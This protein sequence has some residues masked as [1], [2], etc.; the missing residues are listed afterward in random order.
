MARDSLRVYAGF[1][2]LTGRAIGFRRAGV[3]TIAGPERPAELERLPRLAQGMRSIGIDAR[4]VNPAEMR[5]LGN[6]NV[7]DGSLGVWEPGGGYVDPVRTVEQFAALARSLGAVTRTRVAVRA[8]DVR[9]GRVVGLETDEGH[10]ATEHVVVVAGPWSAAL[11]ARAGVELPLRVVRP[12]Q[13]FQELPLEDLDAEEPSPA[14]LLDPVGKLLDEVVGHDTASRAAGPHPVI[15]DLEHGFYTRCD[16]SARRTRVGRID[17][18]HDRV[19]AD[20]DQ[21]DEHVD[22][23]FATWAERSLRRR[24][25]LYDDLPSAGDQAAWYTLSPDA[26]AL[27]GPVDGIEGLL[28]ATGFSGHGFKLAPSVAQGLVQMLF[29]EPV[30]AF[31]REFF[32]PARFRGKPASWSGAFGL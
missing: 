27:I 30:T 6:A 23:T 18:A 14:E 17:Y 11:L 4:L 3:L 20:P 19:I 21:L 22:P 32:D 12:E 16:L 15:I 29:D 25:P 2:T 5:A 7:S 31:D 24:L 13:H 26:Q 10:Y 8:L 28:V 1:E 9:N